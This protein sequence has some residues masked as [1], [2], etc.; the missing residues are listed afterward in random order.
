MFA[1]NFQVELR[2]ELHKV[3][4]HS[5]RSYIEIDEAATEATKVNH[6]VSRSTSHFIGGGEKQVSNEV[7]Y[8]LCDVSNL[9]IPFLLQNVLVVENADFIYIYIRFSFQFEAVTSNG[10]RVYLSTFMLDRMITKIIEKMQPLEAQ[11][12]ADEIEVAPVEVQ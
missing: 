2:E 8:I 7:M 4:S 9:I 12:K 1:S 5:A 10:N 3:T 11:N 6:A